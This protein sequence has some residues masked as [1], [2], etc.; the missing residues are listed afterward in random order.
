MSRKEKILLAEN[1]LLERVYDLILNEET[2]DDERINLVEFK[3]AVGNGKDFEVETMKLAK[4]L[5]LLA[6]KKFNNNNKNLSPGVGKLYMDISST[7]LLKVEF[8]V[9]IIA[10]S[11]VLG[12]H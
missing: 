9:G 6:L 11:G 1:N 8:G 4:S 2:T 10:L 5:R 12:N 3:N 7:G